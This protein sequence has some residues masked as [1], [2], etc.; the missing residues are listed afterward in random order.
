MQDLFPEVYQ[1]VA[2]KDYTVYAYMNDGS[3]RLV[4]MKPFINKGGIF[5][6]L[7][8]SKFFSEKLTILNNTVAWDV[9][10]NRDVYSCI[11]IDPFE[12]QECPIVPDILES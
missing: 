1:A 4:D 9:G 12:I 5:E 3:V 8:N 11:D 6:C 2:G 10:G 7:R